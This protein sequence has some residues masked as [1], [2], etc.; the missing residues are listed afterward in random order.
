ML[1]I[2]HERRR[3]NSKEGETR[4]T[5]TTGLSSVSCDGLGSPSVLNAQ[6]C[7]SQCGHSTEDPRDKAE[8][9][10]HRSSPQGKDSVYG[11]LLMLLN[12]Y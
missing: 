8:D 6:E 3:L 1:L 12:I 4:L 7:G 2:I 5:S 9:S 11:I 10:H